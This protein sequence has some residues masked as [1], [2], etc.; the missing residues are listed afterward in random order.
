[1]ILTLC[2]QVDWLVGDGRVVTTVFQRGCHV[3]GAED[4]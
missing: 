4:T 3:W 2:L 1:M